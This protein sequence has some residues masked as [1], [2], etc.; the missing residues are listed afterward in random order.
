MTAAAEVHTNQYVT[1]Q[2]GDETYAFDVANTREV[3]DFTNI[4]PI[5]N[6]PSWVRGVFNLRGSIIPVLDIKQKFGIGATQQTPDT[7]ILIVELVLGKDEYVLGILADSVREVFEMERSRIEPPPKF[8][9][10]IATHYIRGIGRHQ[11]QFFV[12]LDVEK[13]F[14]T[15]ELGAVSEA[16][17]E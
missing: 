1:F 2:L 14:S 6:T 10:N 17:A 9:A 11:E 7:C 3:V 12:I 13:V 4:T 16:A 15:Q 5:P 8:G